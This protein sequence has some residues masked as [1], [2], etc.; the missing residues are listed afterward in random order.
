[1]PEVK[2]LV[3]MAGAE[4]CHT[5]PPGTI[6]TGGHVAGGGGVHSLDFDDEGRPRHPQRPRHNDG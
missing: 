6:E 1:M 2:P 4:R 3:E 5:T